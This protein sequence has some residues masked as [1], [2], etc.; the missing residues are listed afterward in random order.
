MS[1]L[2]TLAVKDLRILFREKTSIFWV[3]GF[4]LMI[5]LFFGTI[6]SGGGGEVSGMKIAVIDEDQSDYS[7]A[8]IE[9]ISDLSA[10]RVSQM[11]SDSAE[12]KVR[13][14]KLSAVVTFKK[15]FRR[16]IRDVLR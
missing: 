7:K 13:Q 8:Y 6:F 15:R 9:E 1:V 16:I 10:L 3:L 14:G 12:A 2:F 11:S 4:P 5:A